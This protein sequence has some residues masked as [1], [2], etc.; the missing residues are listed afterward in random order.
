[1]VPPE[2]LY[3]GSE[4]SRSISPATALGTVGT[5]EETSKNQGLVSPWPCPH[6]TYVNTVSENICEIC[7]K[8][9]PSRLIVD[10]KEFEEVK[11]KLICLNYT[12][13]SFDSRGIEE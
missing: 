10:L 11:R 6:C 4:R 8:R 3:D 12:R 5:K 13:F 1:M 7:S 9:F 2:D